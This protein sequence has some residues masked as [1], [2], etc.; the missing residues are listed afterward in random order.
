MS[1]R[2]SDGTAVVLCEGN[3]G[4]SDGK[5]AH[6]LVRHTDRYRVLAVI[7][8]R[9]AGRDAGE[10]LDGTPV[11][12][13]VVR[14][15]NAA[16]AQGRPDYL[17]VGV[18]THGGVL[19]SDCRP[20]VRQALRAG[21]NVDSGLHE[22]LGDDPEFAT[23]A[24][25]SGAIIRDVRRTPPRTLMHAFTGAIREVTSVRV[26]VLGTDSAVGKRTTAVRLVQAF[27]ATR[28]RA[29]LIG[30]GQTAW[31][32]GVRYGVILDSLINDFV[33][34]EIEHQVCRAFR[35]EHPDVI[36]I[37]GQG[38]LSN[39]AYPGGFEILAGARP[40][41][42]VLQ[43][44]PGRRHYDGFPDFPLAGVE[45][46]MAIIDLLSGSPVVAITLNHEGLSPTEVRRHAQAYGERHG[47]P[48]CDPLLDGVTP[49]LN[50]IRRRFPRVPG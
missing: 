19:P 2:A 20:M 25:G 38:S 9:C 50:E 15:L 12:I 21:I 5:T 45:K 6:G 7:D 10:I 47:I 24:R 49:V 11:G 32:Q 43:H 13:P 36:V 48:C 3:F 27:N 28:A 1:D 29:V 30:T 44:A 39:P 4:S 8:S 46:E 31:M 41:A 35:E 14:D 26:A 34:G 23:L 16:L 18:A 22:L 40:D 42:I 17:V 37:E 33:S